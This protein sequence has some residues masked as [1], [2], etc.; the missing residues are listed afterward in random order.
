MSDDLVSIDFYGDTLVARRTGEGPR[1]VEV[2][3]RRVCENIGIAVQ[4]QLER[5]K[6]APWAVVTTS[7]MTGPDGKNYTTSMVALR[8]LPMWLANIDA[9]RVA[10]HCR[11]KLVRYQLEAADVLAAHFMPKVEAAVS[12]AFDPNDPRVQLAVMGALTSRVAILEADN[13]SKS[14]AL[15]AAETTVVEQA[16]VIAIAAPKAKAFDRFLDASGLCGLRKAGR[17]LGQCPNLFLES[18]R[19]AKILGNDGRSNFAY[20]QYVDRGYFTHR[21]VVFFNSRTGEDETTDQ[22]FLTG[23]GF[24]WLDDLISTGKLQVRISKARARAQR[25]RAA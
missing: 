18:L 5:L 7:V 19:D 2:S 13:A 14:V 17:D 16:A 24:V 15:A 25:K 6:R 1:D 21:R 12:P 10:A 20:A 3:I 23:D 8:S 11:E 4:G 22:A 9:D